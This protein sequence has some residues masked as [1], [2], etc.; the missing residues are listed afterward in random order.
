MTAFLFLFSFWITLIFSFKSFIGCTGFL[1]LFVCFCCLFCF[2]S[3]L[4]FSFLSPHVLHHCYVIP[5]FSS[6]IFT[7]ILFPFFFICSYLSVS[8]FHFVSLS[9]DFGYNFGPFLCFLLLSLFQSVYCCGKGYC[10]II[11]YNVVCVVS[12]DHTWICWISFD[13]DLCF[14]CILSINQSFVYCK[15]FYNLLI[16]YTTKWIWSKLHIFVLFFTK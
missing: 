15:K 10:F 8:G 9:F 14:Q 1:R 7:F 16:F 12:I 4:L 3:S 13:E 6:L 5:F 11:I 2:V